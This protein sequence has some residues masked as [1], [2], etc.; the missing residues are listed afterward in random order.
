VNYNISPPPDGNDINAIFSFKD[1]NGVWHTCV[2]TKDNLYQL[3][4][5]LS[6]AIGSFNDS[7]PFIAYAQLANTVY[8]TGNTSDNL[9]YIYSWDGTVNGLQV[10]TD[11]FGGRF[12]F[13]LD[14][15]ICI[16][17]TS[18]GGTQFP[19]RVRW[20]VAG[21]PTQWDPSA[22]KGAGFNDLLNTP[23]DITGVLAIGTIAY[24]ARTNG[25]TVMSPTGVGIQPFNFNHLWAAEHGTGNIFPNS[26]ASFGSIGFMVSQE[27]IFAVTVGAVQP[28]G[29]RA[30]ID[31]YNDIFNITLP[32][33]QGV[34]GYIA[35]Q[36]IYGEVSVFQ[37]YNLMIG[38][39]EWSYSLDQK[40][41]TRQ[42]YPTNVLK[43]ICRPNFVVVT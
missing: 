9:G 35:A 25:L 3:I 13:E 30:K 43:G 27:D 39:I 14:A 21:N 33:S 2:T 19:Q 5:G 18:E 40:A 17:N 11:L 36:G 28:I 1:L 29:G 37:S 20:C 38:N 7:M 42:V 22:Y 4:P 16:A 6:N 32:Y 15:S 12:I 23:D 34:I 10:T 24:I 26:M 8:I 31:I 41:W